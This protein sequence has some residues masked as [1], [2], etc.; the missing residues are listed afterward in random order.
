LKH[1]TTGLT[2]VEVYLSRDLRLLLDLLRGRPPDLLTQ[3]SFSVERYNRNLQLK[4]VQIHS[5]ARKRIEQSSR[6][7]AHYDYKA[8]RTLFQEGQKVWHFN[9]RR[10]KGKVSKL[11]S[12]WEEPYLVVKKLS[13]IDYCM[14][15]KHRNKIVHADRLASFLERKV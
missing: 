7:K 2:S 15:P 4:F 12:N 11:Q 3:E 9:C 14:S 1:E 10:E 8:R 6:T 5:E 13:E